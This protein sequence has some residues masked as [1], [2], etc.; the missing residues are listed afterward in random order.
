MFHVFKMESVTFKIVYCIGLYSAKWQR[1]KL[2]TKT[3]SID[4]KRLCLELENMT[5]NAFLM[6]FCRTG[7]LNCVSWIGYNCIKNSC[8]KAE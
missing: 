5:L 3:Q 7:G 6:Q 1:H 8:V 4:T 2:I